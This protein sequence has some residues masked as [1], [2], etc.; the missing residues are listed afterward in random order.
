[1][2]SFAPKVM[3]KTPKMKITTSVPYI[4][5]KSRVLILVSLCGLPVQSAG[6]SNCCHLAPTTAHIHLPRPLLPLLSPLAIDP[7]ALG[8]YECPAKSSQIVLAVALSVENPCVLSPSCIVCYT[9]PAKSLPASGP[10]SHR[11]AFV[12]PALLVLQA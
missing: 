1:M 9:F 8:R 11:Q 12:L 4:K 10:Q 7:A 6:P 3:K 2:T 5:S